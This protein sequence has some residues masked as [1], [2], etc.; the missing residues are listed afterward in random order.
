M[1]LQAAVWELRRYGF[2]AETGSFRAG[3]AREYVHG[4]AVPESAAHGVGVLSTDARAVDKESQSPAHTAVGQCR[5]ASAALVTA[6][7][8]QHLFLYLIPIAV[9]VV[10][11]VRVQELVCYIL[12]RVL[13]DVG[14][15]WGTVVEPWVDLERNAV[16]MLE[17][18]S[19][20]SASC[21]RWA[22]QRK[23]GLCV[24][25]D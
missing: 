17:K 4:F 11:L 25:L 18:D 12:A 14:G 3:A 21:D 22:D 5:A 19:E 16:E 10:V 20:D 2:H 23:K 15:L 9:V 8:P 7:F 24:L 1:K 6:L 13:E